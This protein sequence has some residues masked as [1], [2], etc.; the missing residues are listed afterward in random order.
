MPPS[1]SSPS[2][3]L[4]HQSASPARPA[5]LKLPVFWILR[6]L[7]DSYPGGLRPDRRARSFSA[8]RRWIY[9]EVAAKVSICGTCAAD[10]KRH[11][12]ESQHMRCLC[13]GF[14]AKVSIC[15]TCAADLQRHRSESQQRRYL[16]SGFGAN[17][18]ICGACAADLKRH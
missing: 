7:L 5:R 18:T 11:G 8:K 14:G 16:C 1:T 15:G 9:N 13:S 3:Q 2:V 10:L 12:S 17:V 6:F 4:V